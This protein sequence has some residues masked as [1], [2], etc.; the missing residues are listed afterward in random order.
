[1]HVTHRALGD[2]VRRLAGKITELVPE[3]LLPDL[4]APERELPAEALPSM[5]LQADYGVVPFERTDDELPR[6]A[7]WLAA[8]ERLA[9]RLLTGPG[10]QGKTRL[11]NQFVEQARV[12]GWTAGLLAEQVPVPVLE[13]IHAFDGPV[14]VVVD[15]AEGRTAQIATV[16]AELIARPVDQGPARLLLLARSSGVWPHLLRRHRDDRVSLLFTDLAEHALPSIVAAP[17]DRP[18]EYARALRAFADRSGRPVPVTA[19]PD[20]LGSAR[21]DRVLDV[22]AAALAALLDGADPDTARARRDPLLRVLDHERRHWSAAAVPHELPAPGILRHD[23][24]VSAATLFTARSK[25]EARTLFAALPTFDGAG[26]EAMERH[27]L[28]LA[29]LYPGPDT[30]NPLRPD[31]LGEDLVAATLLDQPEFVEWVAPVVGE[32]Q[33]MRA[34]TILGRAAPR[35]PHVGKAMTTLLAAAPEARLPLAIA[36]ATQLQDTML[37]NVLS[38]VSGTA[39]GLGLDLEESV[40]DHL[41]DSSL[42]LAAFMVVSTRAALDAELHKEQPDAETVATLTHNLSLRLTAVNQHDAALVHAAQAVEMHSQLANEDAEFTPELGSALNTLGGAYS[43]SGFP[44]ECLDAATRSCA[45]LSR[46]ADSSPENRQLY[47]TALINYGNLLSD[48]ARHTEAVAAAEHALELVAE[49]HAEALEE[50]RVERLCRLANAQHNLSAVRAGAGLHSDALTAAEE[51]VRIYRELDAF[52]SDR[53]RDN[54]V[55]ALGNLSGAHSELGQAQGAADI[56]AEAIRLARDLVERHGEGY[57]HFMADVLNN[58]GAALRRLGRHDE[59]IAQLTEAVAL[60]RTLAT[61]SPGIQLP[62]LAGALHNLGDCLLD[63]RQLYKA[64]DVY[65]ESIDIY[66]KLVDPRPDANEPDL[67]ES[68]L[69]LADVLH[70][71]DEYEEALELAEEAAAILRRLAESGEAILRRK[72]AKALHL[73][74]MI[75]DNTGRVLEARD[76][77]ASAAAHLG[78]MVASESENFPDL[79]FEWA[80]MLHT[81]G[82]VLDEAG[83]PDRAVEPF[84]QATEVLRALF[85]E[86]EKVADRELLGD[87]LHDYAV[88]LSGIEEQQEALARI[89]EAV[90]IRRGLDQGTPANRLALCQSLNNLA[91]TLNDLERHHEALVKAD[92]AVELAGALREEDDGELLVHTLVTRASVRAEDAKSAVGDLVRAWHV[93]LTAQDDALVATV[94]HVLQEL[95][96]RYPR[97]VRRA[98]RAATSEPYPLSRA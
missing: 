80:I 70:E 3:L 86:A 56:S 50:D 27:L 77:A 14:L 69:A 65:D 34:L 31:R 78:E 11:A 33:V 79:R 52:S 57:L 91:D 30:L 17:D 41:P 20:D 5:L 54:L 87:V 29:A 73:L 43:Q 12:N 66:R 44:E 62:A 76:S 42:A 96:G 82:N 59:A 32:G 58:S 10:G 67:A 94:L 71:Q 15:Y 93:V 26:H 40:T 38:E 9:T 53:F 48:L 19:P 90:R 60:Y 55:Q 63:T 24:V 16:A 75:Y 51:S 97:R 2:E 68:L 6:L 25:E 4:F 88:S 89:E 72:L 13:R 74:A 84:A 83:C 64:R 37:V 35:H 23:Q 28:W 18:A 7:D 85:R 81:H 22:H 95:A 8:P 92:E 61:V 47:A 39:A 49:L 45:L 1:M 21:Y 36:V 46:V 98:W